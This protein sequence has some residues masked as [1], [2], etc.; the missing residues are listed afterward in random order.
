MKYLYLILSLNMICISSFASWLPQEFV[1]Q[2]QLG[3]F[4]TAS[5]KSKCEKLN[6][7]KVSECIR[8]IGNYNHN[9]YKSVAE[10]TDDVAN[11]NFEAK[12]SAVACVD[13]ADCIQ[14]E[15]D[16][17]CPVSDTDFKY[18][19]IRVADNSEVYCTRIVSFPQ[20]PTGK[21]VAVVDAGLK[22]THDAGKL[23]KKNAKDARKA[24]IKGAI[25]TKLKANQA[26]NNTQMAK[27]LLHL[28]GE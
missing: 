25:L 11:P 20:I 4:F 14:K 7:R 6:P 15:L 16:Q 9:F 24:D 22:S 12:S 13:E 21:Q 27:V 18:V 17:V 3:N 2:E 23:S 8:T 1:G 26:L 28:L 10:Q 19:V 5:S